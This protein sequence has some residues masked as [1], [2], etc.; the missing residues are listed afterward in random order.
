[1]SFPHD[2]IYRKGFLKDVI[3]NC[4]LGYQ[5]IKAVIESCGKQL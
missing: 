1:M 4:Y 2:K 3:K 5:K